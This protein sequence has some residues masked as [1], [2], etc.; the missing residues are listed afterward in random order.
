MDA[1]DALLCFGYKIV[2]EKDPL[3]PFTL[4][5]KGADLRFRDSIS[6][7]LKEIQEN[8]KYYAVEIRKKG[9]NIDL[10]PPQLPPGYY[11]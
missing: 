11:K 4:S 10:P 7:L 3:K 5:G 6:L 8:V 1:I 2:R 9:F